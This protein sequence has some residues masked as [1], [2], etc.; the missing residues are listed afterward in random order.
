M[1]A[2]SAM[3]PGRRGHD[4]EAVRERI[5]STFSEKARSSGTRSIVMGELAA[6]LRMSATTL[7]KHFPSKD[8]MVTALVERWAE[9]LAD[10][11]AAST[12]RIGDSPTDGLMY[13]ATS[14]S[15]TVAKYS[16]A[17]WEDIQRD[18]PSACA[19][20]WKKMREWRSRG[21]E[22]LRPHLRKDLHPEMALATLGLILENAPNPALCERLG[23][24]RQEAIETSVAIW[25]RGALVAS[26]TIRPLPSV[27]RSK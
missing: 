7:Y 12:Q 16:P 24:T 6:E 22:L 2:K 11:R 26:G 4:E 17:F 8:D 23:I 27:E 14:W 21:A 18:H 10:W 20:F 19:I 5:L 25:A 15:K 3:R 1:S 13:W 9:D